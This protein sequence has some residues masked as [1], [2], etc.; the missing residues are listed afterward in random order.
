MRQG[1][2]SWECFS[3]LLKQSTVLAN[4][5]NIFFRFH[6]W[7]VCTIVAARLRLRVQQKLGAVER[8]QTYF[9]SF[10]DLRRRKRKNEN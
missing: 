4:V 8:L 1:F 7:L 10:I 6:F 9:D 5:C 2:S 3:S